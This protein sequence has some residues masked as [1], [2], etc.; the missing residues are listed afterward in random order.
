MMVNDQMTSVENRTKRTTILNTH[1]QKQNV[2]FPEVHW[3]SRIA[4]H[5][6]RVMEKRD[7]KPKVTQDNI[8]RSL[9][10]RYCFKRTIITKQ[11]LSFGERGQSTHFDFFY[12]RHCEWMYIS[13]IDDD[14]L[15]CS[16]V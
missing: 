2:C 9:Y 8:I 1:F 13:C 7:N 4:I 14:V 3:K 15:H 11:L 12:V 6:P 10:N 16:E 5:S